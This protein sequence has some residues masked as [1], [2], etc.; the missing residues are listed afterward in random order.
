MKDFMLRVKEEK[1][2]LDEKISK[3]SDFMHSDA[4]LELSNVNQGLLMLQ[5]SQMQSYSATLFRRIELF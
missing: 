5:L 1:S 4:Y 3:L 2:D